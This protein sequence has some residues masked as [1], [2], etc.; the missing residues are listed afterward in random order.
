MET[1][2][3]RLY[4]ETAALYKKL[5]DE[6]DA[7]T[8]DAFVNE[9]L[10]AL[11]NPRK[12]EVSKASDIE[13]LQIAKNALQLAESDLAGYDIKLKELELANQGLFYDN[14]AQAVEIRILKTEILQSGV[15]PPNHILFP[16]EEGE[17]ETFEVWKAYYSKLYK[18]DFTLHETLYLAISQK[19]YK[20]KA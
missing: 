16:I 6:S 14:E 15:I 12:L 17:M 2:S 8:A 19:V 9:M 13:A 5:K 18:R 20:L 10:E 7:T 11:R 3:I 1:I 4:P